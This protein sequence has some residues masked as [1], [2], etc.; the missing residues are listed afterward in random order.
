MYFTPIEPNTDFNV[1]NSFHTSKQEHVINFKTN[2]KFE[3]KH[4]LP[5][6]IID[7]TMSFFSTFYA[8]PSTTT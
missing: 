7:I 3:E 8:S 1:G 4:N 6:L 5:Q 2:I